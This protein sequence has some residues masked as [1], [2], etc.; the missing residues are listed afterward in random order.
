MPEKNV[1]KIGYENASVY[2]SLSEKDVKINGHGI[3]YTT[4]KN[5]II[6]KFDILIKLN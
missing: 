3:I 4:S 1:I 2:F 5:N 6:N